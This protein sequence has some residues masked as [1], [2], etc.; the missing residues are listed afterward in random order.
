[1][2]NFNKTAPDELGYNPAD[3]DPVIELAR[4]Q[5]AEPTSRVLDASQLRAAQFGLVKGGYQIAAVDQA[6]ERL[7]DAFAVNEAKRLT[8]QRGHHGA[9]LFLEE[10]KATLLGRAQRPAGHKFKRNPFW[11]KGYSKHQVDLLLA[12]VAGYFEGTDRIT[13][14]Q[15]RKVVFSPR[16]G[17]YVEN[18]VDAY[19]DRVVEHLQ[20]GK[21]IL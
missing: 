1:M 6:L 7:D 15:L 5:F 11:V 19:I 18:Q 9:F 8:A 17:G 12:T 4:R 10:L 16:W 2:S 20:V 3:V 13:V 21:S 14:E